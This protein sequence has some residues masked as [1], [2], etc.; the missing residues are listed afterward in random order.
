MTI[1]TLEQS[2][3]SAATVNLATA[4]TGSLTHV[5]V[6]SAWSGQFATAAGAVANQLRQPAAPVRRRRLAF[7]AVG[8]SGTGITDQMDDL[9][10]AGFGQD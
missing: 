3:T 5:S 7:G 1:F 9:L 2:T 8:A 4:T 6:S 10:A